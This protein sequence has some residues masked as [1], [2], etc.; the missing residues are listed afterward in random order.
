MVV[1]TLCGR[2]SNSVSTNTV[3]AKA[4]E[5]MAPWILGAIS[6][7]Y[8]LDFSNT[9]CVRSAILH[10]YDSIAQHDVACNLHCTLTLVIPSMRQRNNEK[11]K[12]KPITEVFEREID[13]RRCAPLKKPRR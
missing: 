7:L 3:G 11:K 10:V 8:D 13:P 4:D 2:K 6:R 9:R 12:K 1:N 5:T